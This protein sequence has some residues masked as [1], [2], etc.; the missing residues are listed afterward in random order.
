MTPA[1]ASGA[2]PAVGDQQVLGQQRAPTSSSVV[3]CSP[4]RARRTTIEPL[5]PETSNACSGWPS[6]EHDVV[7]DVDGQRDRPHARLG[8]ALL[9][10]VRRGPRGVDAADDPGD[11]AVAARRGPAAARRRRAR[12]GSRGRRRRSTGEGGRVAEGA[13]GGVAVLAGDAAQAEAVAAVGGDVDLDDLVLE[14]EQRDRVVAGLERAEDLLVALEPLLQH[15]DAVVVL[16]EAELAGGADHPVADV[17]VGLARRDG[18]AAGQHRAGQ[19]DDDEVADGEVEGAAD[20]ALRGAVGQPL[21]VL[22]DVDLA[23]ADGLA[24]L[25]R[26]LDQLQHPADDERAGDVAAVQP[27]LLQADPDEAGGDVAA[28]RPRRHVDVVAQPGDRR[29]HQISIPNCAPKRTSPSTMSCMSCDA[30]AQHQ[31]RARCPSRRR[32]RCSGRGRCRRPAAP[33]G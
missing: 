18:E 15:D 17:A 1:M 12:P 10:P 11:V 21:A 6:G 20:D 24:V 5:R 23:P 32:T 14:A 27:L 19:D 7:G 30:V 31:R 26:L 29:A 13:A 33:C 2:L 4:G 25:L 3:S 8:E 9:H 22:A 16:A 28:G